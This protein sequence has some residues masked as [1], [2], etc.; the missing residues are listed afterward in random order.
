[1]SKIPQT[2]RAVQIAIVS[3]LIFHGI[4]AIHIPNEGRRSAIA[5]RRLK[6]EG[7]LKGAPDLCCVGDGGLTAWLEVK[8]AK[9][10][11]SEAQ[12]DCHALLRRKGHFVAV[13]RSQDQAVAA[14][15]EAGFTVGRPA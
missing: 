8:T 11:L 2:E 7:M 9:G 13:V 10:R 15:R 5:G 4:V 14:L 12:A 3:R 1:M 6:Q